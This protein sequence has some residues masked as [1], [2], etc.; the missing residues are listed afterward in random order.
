[1]IGSDQVWVV[2]SQLNMMQHFIYSLQNQSVKPKFMLPLHYFLLPFPLGNVN[3]FCTVSLLCQKIIV[4]DHVY[5]IFSYI[6]IH[7]CC[8]LFNS[9][10]VLKGGG[11]SSLKYNSSR[12]QTYQQVRQSFTNCVSVLLHF[13]VPFQLSLLRAIIDVSVQSVQRAALL[14]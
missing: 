1:M 7:L 3:L 9:Y 14:F 12:F 6:S 4:Y 8:Y 5:I 11:C 13:S 10:V 2:C